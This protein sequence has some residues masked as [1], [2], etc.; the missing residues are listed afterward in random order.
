MT[1]ALRDSIDKQNLRMPD[2]SLGKSSFTV[3][4]R[5]MAKPVYLFERIQHVTHAQE[6]IRKDFS[7]T[8]GCDA[9]D[10][11]GRKPL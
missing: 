3:K 7:D 10:I 8:D 4:R 1:A 2:G 11:G 5:R 9:G 6:L